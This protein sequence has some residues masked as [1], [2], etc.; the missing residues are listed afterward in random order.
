M[1]E[2]RQY[3]AFL[4]YA[5]A[6]EDIATRVHK[7]LETYPVPRA[8][9]GKSRGKLAPIF[10]DVT[11]LTAHHS[12]TEKIRHAV[13]NS[14]YLIVLCSPASK[15]SHWVNE[16]IRLFRKLH[17]ENSILCALLE[18][19]PETSFPPALTEG[20]R[21]PL[22]ADLTGAKESFKFGLTQMAAAM[23]GVG[24]D[25]LVQREAR[26]KRM[27]NGII[28]A[29]SL[30][31]S[32]V[33]GVMA[34]MAIDARDEAETSR[35]EAEKMVEYMLTDLKEEL[36]KV[37]RLSILDAVGDRVTEYYQAI[38]LS[39]MDDDRLSR[40][41]RALH[42][43]GDVAL[44]QGDMDKAEEK[45]NAAYKV[46]EE[47]YR[48]APEDPQAIFTHSQSVYWVGKILI[49]QQN[50]EAAL[51]SRIENKNLSEK[52]YQYDPTQRLNLIEYASSLNNLG[53][54]YMRLDDYEESAQS[55]EEAIKLLEIY[56]ENA[57][58]VDTEVLLKIARYRRNLGATQQNAGL[59]GSAKQSYLEQISVLESLLKQEPNNAEYME[60]ILLTRHWLLD[61]NVHNF[62]ICSAFEMQSFSRE[63]KQLL[64]LK[65]NDQRVQKDF[66]KS[67]YDHNKNCPTLYEDSELVNVISDALSVYKVIANKSD[68]D[69]EAYK[70]L[71][72]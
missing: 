48:R 33:M 57:E 39:D 72:R 3:A 71:S 63:T 15:E 51:P 20:G 32:A 54:L 42:L 70:W 9:K 67:V 62:D 26:R 37:G 18:G 56:Q 66:L 28:T 47:I 64:Y 8:L 31:F 25:E 24:L 68:I 59:Y 22:A 60:Q 27:R 61:L 17:G 40:E 69:K 14:R 23:L 44:T 43:L 45:L 12:L 5:H 7:G 53:V 41:A 35:S 6:D 49:D 11:E 2:P 13:Q 4:S 34:W 55:Y 29:A 52:L 21:E 46:T 65:P 19:T 1:G 36:D 58:Y 16:E 30:A 10:R 50:Y 38:P